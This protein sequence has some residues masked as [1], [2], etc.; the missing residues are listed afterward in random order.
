MP[1]RMQRTVSPSPR[2]QL[3]DRL[4]L[5]AVTLLLIL[6]AAFVV[7]AWSQ[8]GEVVQ[9]ARRADDHRAERLAGA[10][11]KVMER[12]WTELRSWSDMNTSLLEPGREADLQ[13]A[14][15]RTVTGGSTV[16]LGWIVVRPDGTFAA[17]AETQ[18][19]QL[20]SSG[21]TD[22]LR[23]LGRQSA[24]RGEPLASGRLKVGDEAVFATA[25]PIGASDH[26]SRLGAVI[27][28]S[29]LVR[30]SFGA[31]IDQTGSSEQD[32]VALLD[33][34][35]RLLLGNPDL[36]GHDL[37]H[38][39]VGRTG[40]S[41][42][43]AHGEISSFLPGWAYPGFALLLVV[44]A[45]AYALQDINGR[46]QRRRGDARSRQVHA[47]YDLAERVLHARSI[48]SQ[49]QDLARSAMKLAS[50]DAAT[51][52]VTSV[53]GMVEHSAGT[54]AA[55][56][57]KY[58]VPIIGPREPVGELVVARAGE[59]LD[60][61]EQWVVQTAATLV[62]AAMHTLVSLETERAAAAE[63]QRLDE[64]RSNLLA[65][66]AHELLSPLTAVKGVLGLMS[67]QDD[68]G[69]R[70][71]EYVGVAT[72]RT[73][74][75]VAL[76]RDLFDCS[77]LETGQLDIRP[78]R[79]RADELLESALGAQA[80]ARSGELRLSATPNLMITVDPVRFDQLVNNLVTNAFRHGAPPVEV[81]VRPGDG[82]TLVIVSDEGGGIPL[83]D[84][85]EIFGK[86][87]QASSGHART[88]QGAGLGLN[89]VQGLVRVHGGD[90]RVD[91]SHA[92][93]RGARFT[94]FFPDTTP[95][96]PNPSATSFDEAEPTLV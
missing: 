76:I 66:V 43:F 82:G 94:A 26:E 50:V 19:G 55:G 35:H 77:L 72:E 70:G 56:Q 37:L 74:R 18:A 31:F 5:P 16:Q 7:A 85:S 87:W 10:V 30:S 78:R 20:T 33:G 60:E 57:A 12:R 41:I 9:E 83:E 86:F 34:R 23:T 79:Q 89:L 3:V 15:D 61:E 46:R 21:I 88:S 36:D 8:A 11:S 92:D 45:L 1:H 32:E 40:W 47:L 65:T 24:R 13:H 93:G 53:D 38:E 84:R 52:Y 73:D 51:V 69:E 22:D 68:L 6:G 58:R 25:W 90:I 91:S 39:P 4:M 75:L 59:Q 14:V 81:A 28:V 54:T 71:R 96:F 67:M 64:L 63:L 62:G 29:N 44:F 49:A 80:A 42:A 2:V 17:V 27:S 48:E 95:E